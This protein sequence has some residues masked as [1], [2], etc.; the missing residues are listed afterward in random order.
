MVSTIQYKKEKILMTSTTRWPYA[1]RLMLLNTAGLLRFP[2]AENIIIATSCQNQCR[3]WFLDSTLIAQNNSL[4]RT[5]R[6]GLFH[7]HTHT[8]TKTTDTVSSILA[9]LK[10]VYVIQT[11]YL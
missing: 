11:F 8:H 1:Q 6:S 10:L 2:E 3:N 5:P 7:T 9:L 4:W